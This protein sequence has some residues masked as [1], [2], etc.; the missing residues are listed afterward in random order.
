MSFSDSALSPPALSNAR[1]TPEQQSHIEQTGCCPRPE[2]QPMEGSGPKMQMI[3][4]LGWG[5]VG[6]ACNRCQS[7]WV[8][9]PPPLRAAM[10]RTDEPQAT[11]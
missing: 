7:I 5:A 10:P 1:M 4:D 9:T 6:L 3:A 2:C 8:V 11:N